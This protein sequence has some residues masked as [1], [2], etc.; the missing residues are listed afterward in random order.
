MRT[1]FPAA[2]FF[3]LLVNPLLADGTNA[4]TA[5]PA[6]TTKMLAPAYDVGLASDG[7][8]ADQDSYAERIGEKNAP[9]GEAYIVIFRL[10]A[11]PEGQ[12]FANVHL[13]MQMNAKSNEGG[14]LAAADLYGLGLRDATKT[15]PGD[16]YQGP[17]PDPKATLI[18]AKILTPDSPVRTDPN[19]GPFVETNADGDVAL[20]K[21]FNDAAQPGSAG[22]YLFLRISYDVDP[23]PSGNS[24]YIILTSGANGDNEPP[25]LSYTLV[26]GAGK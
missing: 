11:L 15:L 23:I 22:K 26:P 2:A 4:P 10:P 5:V 13:R 14:T 24:A 21:Y 17:N 20:T 1:F 12:R 7:K 19:T 25:L 18:E 16:Y 9:G 3:L 8:E 6:A